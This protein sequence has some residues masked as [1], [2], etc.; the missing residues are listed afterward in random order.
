MLENVK[1]IV[2]QRQAQRVPAC[3]LRIAYLCPLRKKMHMP[4]E[5]KTLVKVGAVSYS[6]TLPLLYGMRKMPVLQQ[7]DLLT[8]YPSAVAE[9]LI[10]GTIDVGLVPVAVFH[11]VANAQI[12][13]KYG[14]A[15]HGLVA[16]VCIFS[17]VPME[18]ITHVMLDYQ[19]RTS[20]ALAQ[21]LL[22]H[23]WKQPVEL[24]AATP[25]FEQQIAGS[26]AAVV[27]GDRAL[28]LQSKHAHVYDLAEAWLQWTGLPFVFAAW[29]A[30]KPLP[31]DFIQAFDEANALGMAH[32]PEIVAT[33]PFPDYDLQYY[34]TQNIH[35]ELTAEKMQGLQLFL[36][37]LQQPENAASLLPASSKHSNF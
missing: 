23:F 16:S 8:D 9:K 17:D 20:V 37:M 2:G 28:S 13:G 12:V 10:A 22:K 14:I 15:A 3:W 11:K 29:I 19:S 31:A 7:M 34:F 33:H 36:Q 27:I 26:T 4:D 18:Q 21:L 6:N 5:S 35:Y 1:S 32:I 30:N 25:G 24:V